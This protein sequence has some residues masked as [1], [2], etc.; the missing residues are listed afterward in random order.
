ME[1]KLT[2]LLRKVL[3]EKNFDLKSD[4]KLYSD[5]DLLKIKK[6]TTLIKENDELDYL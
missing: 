4:K 6:K 1:N 3:V 5:F 2:T